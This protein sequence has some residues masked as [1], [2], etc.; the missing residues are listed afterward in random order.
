MISFFP[1]FF[2]KN[3]FPEILHSQ[4]RG[5]SAVKAP[6]IRHTEEDGGEKAYTLLWF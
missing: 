6:C 4:A 5:P 2:I 3:F 1:D